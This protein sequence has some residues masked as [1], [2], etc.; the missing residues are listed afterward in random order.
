MTVGPGRLVIPCSGEQLAHAGM[1]PRFDGPEAIGQTR[2]SGTHV[3]VRGLR[4][5]RRPRTR[6]RTESHSRDASW[7]SRTGHLAACLPAPR[8]GWIHCGNNFLV[9]LGTRL[10]LPL[11]HPQPQSK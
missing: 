7:R 11:H 1:G 2:A 9:E 8:N 5:C 6:A 10:C 3:S 4:I